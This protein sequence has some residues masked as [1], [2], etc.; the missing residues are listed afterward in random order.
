MPVFIK[1]EHC[2]RAWMFTCIHVSIFCFRATPSHT[3]MLSFNDKFVILKRIQATHYTH[4]SDQP[5]ANH[6]INTVWRHCITHCRTIAHTPHTLWRIIA[7]APFT[8]PNAHTPDNPANLPLA[9]HGTHLGWRH[10][11]LSTERNL[12]DSELMMSQGPLMTSIHW[13]EEAMNELKRFSLFTA[14]FHHG[15]AQKQ[16]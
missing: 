4:P 16:T 10:S 5:L 11:P 1:L 12:V 9:I 13:R 8:Q 2:N 15:M 3:V 6:R 7:P 14:E